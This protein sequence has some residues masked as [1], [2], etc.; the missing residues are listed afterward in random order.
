MVN[1]PPKKNFLKIGYF[2]TIFILIFSEQVPRNAVT[3]INAI[4]ESE[5]RDNRWAD[6]LDLTTVV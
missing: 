1:P 3:L 5:R 2:D 4:A 6:T